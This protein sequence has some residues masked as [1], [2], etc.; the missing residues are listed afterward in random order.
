M[1]FERDTDLT[2]PS[3]IPIFPLPNALLLPEGQLPLNIFEPRYLAMIEDALGAPGRLIGMVQPID[4]DGALFGI[5]CAGRISYFQETGD[6]RFMIALNGV[7]RFR[8]G[9]HHL[10]ERGYRRATVSWDEFTADLED[11]EGGIADRDRMFAVMRR[12]FDTQGF[13]ADWDQIERSDDSAIL[14]TLAMVCPFDVAEKQALLEAEGVRS[15][16]DLLIAMMEMALHGDEGQ[17]DARH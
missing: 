6:G 8:L 3:Q 15:R 16:A 7:C 1:T 9:G 10:T 2:L 17:N 5:G 11:G 12:Y 14:N 4:E 13:E